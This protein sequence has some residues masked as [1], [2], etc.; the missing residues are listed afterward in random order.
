VNRHLQIVLISFLLVGCASPLKQSWNDFTAYYNTFY[1]AKQYYSE[2]LKLN[3]SQAPELGPMSFIRIHPP[4]SGA[5]YEQFD[6]AIERGASILRNHENSK[7][8]N[9]ALFIIGKSYFY[10]SE[11]FS[12]LEKFQ[13]LQTVSAGRE[14]QEAILWQARTYLEM[15][16][17]EEG[18]R[19]LEFEKE[20]IS[21]WDSD[22]LF[23]LFA[24]EAQF[25][26]ELEEW[27]SASNSLHKSASELQDRDMQARAYFL[28]GQVL[29]E[30]END[31]QALAAF[32]LA[33]ITG[34]NYNLEYNALRKQAE[35]SR[36]L[37]NYDQAARVYRAI[38]RDDKFIDYRPDMRYEIART[39]QLSGA[40]EE[41]VERYTSLL[42]NRFESLPDITKAKTYFAL[43]EIY[44]DD[45]GVFSMAASY[46]DSAASMRIDTS[47]LPVRFN[48]GEQAASFGEYA[49]LK[50]EIA[51]HDSL[52]HLAS[53]TP[54]EL[55]LVIAEVQ[56]QMIDNQEQRFQDERRR[57]ET[58]I[59][60]DVSPDDVIDATESLE[61]GFLNVK[62]QQ[63]LA[64]A[65]LRFQA[66]W[67]DRPLADNWR[68][69]AAVSGSRFDQPDL[70][71]GVAESVIMD[72]ENGETHTIS[73]FDLSDIPY[74]EN[75]KIE[76]NI[77]KESYRYRLANLFFLSLDMPDS[78]KVY[79]T[80]VIESDVSPDL[81]MR[82]LYSLTELNLLSGNNAE[83]EKWSDQLI[84]DYPESVFTER[85][86]GRMDISGR[87]FPLSER[88]EGTEYSYARIL[89]AD[90][91]RNPAEKAIEL[92]KLAME[93]ANE[94]QRPLLLLEAAK[95][96]MSAAMDEMENRDKVS[97]WLTNRQNAERP[98][99]QNDGETELETDYP[100]EGVYWDSTRSVLNYL[101]ANYPSS[102]IISRVR[103]LLR[104]LEK[105]EEA[106]S[107]TIAVMATEP[108]P[109]NRYPADPAPEP[110]GCFD[111]GFELDLEGGMT[112]FMNRVNFP[113][114]AEEMNMRGEISYRLLINAE[115]E[116]ESYDQLSRMDRTGIPQA[117]E[118]AMDQYLRFLPHPGAR[119]LNCKITFPID[120]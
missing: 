71:R 95:Q 22:I 90:T 69:R 29:E 76:M 119:S 23:E 98:A 100:F 59:V 77:S 28:H 75:E 32:R 30:M 79:Y 42:Q 53:L 57:S 63:L 49:S 55:D 44:R 27:A 2:G 97:E 7:Y 40:A 39:Y 17:I 33:S 51:R 104:S 6:L 61:F 60:S 9:P 18:L 58:M 38:A 74:T 109:E 46:F 16:A 82:A 15:S 65:S 113:D 80:N 19:L 85:I 84:R 62:S 115:G 36:K 117:I 12:A 88:N 3:Q 26:V 81:T 94:S 118:E 56:Q 41:A 70:Q 48:A 54:E 68:R 103:I 111:M 89:H 107:D 93:N 24:V 66:I 101:E 31:F 5:G 73:G 96:Y 102:P 37:G 86:A 4:P 72:P 43:G 20:Q 105:P 50:R 47:L 52:I 35:M 87:R 10:K 112:A 120:L 83:A 34:T 67:G 92:H 45:L 106:D 21:E 99:D 25:Y 14:L 64:D 91:L 110:A 78:A 108:F 13:E 114:W 1:N 116:V 11:Y 8:V